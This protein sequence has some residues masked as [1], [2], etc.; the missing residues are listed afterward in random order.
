[1]A[2]LIIKPSADGQLILKDEGDDAALT[3]GTDGNTTL[4]GTGNNLGTVTAGTFP[5]P[6]ATA[7]YPAGHVLQVVSYYTEAQS[8]LT[9]SDSDQVV[10][11]MTKVVTPKGVN[12]K[13]LVAVR[14]GGEGNQQWNKTFNIQMDGTRVNVPSSPAGSM[15]VRGLGLGAMTQ[16]HTG[17]DND[18]TSE[19]MSFSPLISTSSAIGTGITFRLVCSGSGHDTTYF[20]RCI[21]V[22]NEEFTSELIITEIKG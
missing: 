10:N 21:G 22:N 20:N 15:G 5:V 2:N 7:L 3:I 8:S 12:S 16:T 4:S 9:I 6:S 19:G 17:A 1:M 18:S 11:G 14:I 13:F